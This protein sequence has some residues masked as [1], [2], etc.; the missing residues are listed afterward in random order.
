[1]CKARKG[2]MPSQ[3]D[4]DDLQTKARALG[5]SLNKLG[6]S[7]RKVCHRPYLTFPLLPMING[8]QGAIH[9]PTRAN[10]PLHARALAN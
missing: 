7:R 10:R 1:M 6:S 4:F 2:Q 8:P 9:A 3:S 5:A